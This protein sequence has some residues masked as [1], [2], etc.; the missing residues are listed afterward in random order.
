MKECLILPMRTTKGERASVTQ[1][2][3]PILDGLKLLMTKGK[4]LKAQNMDYFMTLK[5]SKLLTQNV[6]IIRKIINLRLIQSTTQRGW[7]YTL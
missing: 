5:Q 6:K 7:K 1:N 2:Q 3:K 4:W